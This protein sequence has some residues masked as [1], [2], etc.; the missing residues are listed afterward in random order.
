MISLASALASLPFDLKQ[1]ATLGFPGS[2]VGKESACNAEDP[3]SIP[4]LGLS[5]WRRDR[6]PTP[7]V[8]ICQP[9][10]TK[11]SLESWWDAEFPFEPCK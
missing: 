10:Q 11:T 5:P 2:S 6:L 1:N 3:S 7:E 4:G 9:Q 8:C